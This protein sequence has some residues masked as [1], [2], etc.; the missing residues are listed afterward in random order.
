MK[1]QSE[2]LGAPPLAQTARP[3]L[4]VKVQFEKLGL[5][6]P[7]RT[8]PQETVPMSA[9]R[10]DIHAAVDRTDSSVF[11]EKAVHKAGIA[12][13]NKDSSTT[14]MAGICSHVKKRLSIPI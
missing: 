11:N 4:L 1:R 8:A 13:V 12:T 7:T 14:R 3:M 6:L 5:P 2:K 9:Q 10:N